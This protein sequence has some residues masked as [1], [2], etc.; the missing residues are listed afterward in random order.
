M[1]IGEISFCGKVG[2]NIKSDEYKQQILE[3]LKNK[4]GFK[5]IQKHFDRFSESMIPRLNNNP[6]ILTVRTNGNPYLLYL[7]RYNYANQCIFIDKKIQHGYFYPRMIIVK[8]WF[9]D[10]LFNDTLID[11]EMVKTN[12]GVWEYLIH[13]LISERG[14]DF[15]KVNI[16][17]RINRMHEI[18]RT[19][20][21][22]DD[23]CC[24]RLRVKKFFTYD[25]VDEMMTFITNLD[26]SCRGIYF[27]PLFL[28]F[29]DVLVNFEDSLVKKVVRMKMKDV[30]GSTFLMPNEMPN[31]IPKETPK[32]SLSLS[33]SSSDAGSVVLSSEQQPRDNEL[34]KIFYARKTNQPDVY[35]LF[36]SASD[37]QST[38]EIAC[39]S[40]LATSK[41]MRS[42]FNGGSLTEK[43]RV[44]CS[45]SEKFEK[46]VPIHIANV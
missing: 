34:N 38:P 25:R 10:E 45:W 27:K 19:M 37:T 26:Y 4:V 21:H 41:L 18:L 14:R 42:M 46:W 12:N 1:H 15:S 36:S 31:E 43:K 29:N 9:D 7:T 6:H 30:N 24:C 5:V 11:G 3:D 33:S 39:V 22:E 44:M 40:S 28:K 13:D 8:L 16:V 2:Y 32:A 23:V 35:E 20:Y 17:K